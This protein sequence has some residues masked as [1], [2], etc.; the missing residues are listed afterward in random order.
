MARKAVQ[1]STCTVRVR[2]IYLAAKS[3]LEDKDTTSGFQGQ[4]HLEAKQGTLIEAKTTEFC[5][6]QGQF[7]M[8]PSL[9]MPRWNLKHEGF[10]SVYHSF[11]KLNNVKCNNMNKNWRTSKD[12]YQVPSFQGQGLHIAG[13]GLN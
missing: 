5:P 6:R 12:K 3:R 10:R 13:Q 11:Q 7:S 4:G 2:K 8:T 1:C 9:Q